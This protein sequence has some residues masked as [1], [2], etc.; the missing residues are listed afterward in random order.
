[1]KTTKPATTLL[2]SLELLSSSE[3]EMNSSFKA[4]MGGGRPRLMSFDMV[5][6]SL[7]MKAKYTCD[8]WKGLYLCIRDNKKKWK[9]PTYGNF[10]NTIKTFLKFLLVQIEWLLLIN[11]IQFLTRKDKIAFVDSTPLPVCKLIRSNRHKTMKEFAEYSKSTMGFYFGFKLHLTCD[12]NTQKPIHIMFSNAKLDDRKYLEK[13][14]KNEFINTG[15]M[16]V[17]DKGYQA[18]WL[19]ELAKETGN[20]LITGKR[21]SKKTRTLASQ[22]DIYLL[23]N[24]AKIESIFGTLKTNYNLTTTKSRSILGYLF[25]YITSLFTYLIR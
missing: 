20:Y 18:R 5:M 25:N 3:L 11:Q 22:F 2:N 7:E 13:L 12:Y 14:L 19:E 4:F 1:M 15:T 9:L 16:F 17:A 23:H 6:E 21:K 10:L 8:T 24:R